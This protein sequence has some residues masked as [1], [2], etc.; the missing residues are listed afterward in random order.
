MKWIK[1]PIFVLI[2]IGFTSCD[3]SKLHVNPIPDKPAPITII[4]QPFNDFSKEETDYVANELKE[5]YHDVK[6]NEPI[7][8]PE[9]ALNKNKTRYRADS[10]I[11][12]LSRQT[13][14][15]Y[16]T[17]GLTKSDISVPKGNNPDWGVF[18]LGYRPGNSCIAS[19]YRLKGKNKLEKLFK[20]AI[21]ELGHTEGLPH[22]TDKNCLMRSA[23]GKDRFDELHSFC[24]HCKSVLIDAGWTLK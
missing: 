1:L 22:C 8:L 6:I 13:E 3:E 5:I 12:Y 18:G 20:V 15:G 23:E 16:K 11:K 19:L 4:V 10:L 21:H 17:I 24:A 7:E 14:V 2:I 9:H